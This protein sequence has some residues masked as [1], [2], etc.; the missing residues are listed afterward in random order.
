MKLI[1]KTALAILIIVTLIGAIYSFGP[2]PTF[3]EVDF[4]S[5]T[6]HEN[7][8]SL[9]SIIATEESKVID[10]KPNNQARIVWANN[11]KEKTE[12]S[13]VYLHGF[14]ASQME[15]HPVHIDLAKKY[16]CNLYLPRLAEHGRVDT[17]AFQNLTPDNLFE[18]A[19]KALEIGRKIGNKVIIMS[20]STGGTLSIMLAKNNP[21]I[22][23]YIMYSPNIDIKDPTSTL[24][25]EQWGPQ[26]TSMV[27]GSEYNRITYTPEA[28]KYWNAVYHINGIIV[29]KRL[30]KDYM[31]PDYFAH[32]KRPLLMSYYYKNDLENDDV[33]SV[34]RMLE[35]F[36]QIGTPHSL[37]RKIAYDDI[38]RHVI[39]SDVMTD[40]TEKV[41]EDTYKFVEEVLGLNPILEKK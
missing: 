19:Q 30:I 41:K 27:L 28:Q 16:G 6:I 25:T 1:K 21:D 7:L 9:D 20:C 40:K 4:K 3:K 29:T 2:K 37:K 13:I 32:V 39:C 35:F 5:P 12:Y 15:G 8:A 36:D 33:V 14:S 34:P 10:L 31:T 38:T 17:N 26:I 11:N 23:G 24:V 18:S 22:H